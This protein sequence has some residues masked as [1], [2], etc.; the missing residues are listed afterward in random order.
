MGIETHQ[1]TVYIKKYCFYIPFHHPNKISIF[2]PAANLMQIPDTSRLPGRKMPQILRR[3]YLGGIPRRKKVS[4]P[5]QK[6]PRRPPATKKVSFPARKVPH[7]PSATKISPNP[8]QNRI[9]PACKGIYLPF[10]QSRLSLLGQKNNLDG[11]LL[12]LAILRMSNVVRQ[13]PSLWRL[14]FHPPLPPHP[15]FVLG[16]SFPF[17]RM[18][19]F[20][21]SP[22]TAMDH[23]PKAILGDFAVEGI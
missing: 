1:R 17:R 9:P 20:M 3:S 5:A 18:S 15:P 16:K 21:Q 11:E 12:L 4:F 2:K 14:F 23:K 7:T 6:V 13:A 8:A 10:T 19:F 22:A